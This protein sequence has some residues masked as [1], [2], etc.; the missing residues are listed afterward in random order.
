MALTSITTTTTTFV[1]SAKE[2]RCRTELQLHSGALSWALGTGFLVVELGASN[3]LSCACIPSGK[4]D[5]AFVF[6]RTLR[7]S[8][9]SRYSFRDQETLLL[10]PFYT[11]ARNRA[12]YTSCQ[13]N[14]HRF[15]SIRINSIFFFFITAKLYCIIV[16][17]F[18]RQSND[19]Q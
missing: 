4:P 3:V 18:S 13:R 15:Y 8:Y 7:Y 14:F 2:G 10:R 11:V 1:S 5:T 16:K 12:L 6:P 17:N 19:R 9:E